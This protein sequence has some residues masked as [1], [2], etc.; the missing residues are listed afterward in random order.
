MFPCA[1]VLLSPA[2][3]LLSAGAIAAPI[4]DQGR[5]IFVNHA[6][7]GAN[8]GTSWADAFHHPRPALAT[9]AQGDEIWIARGSYVTSSTGDVGQSFRVERALRMFGG[10]VGNE[11]VR[12]QRN[13]YLHRT[14]LTGRL[15]GAHAQHVVVVGH[16]DPGMALLDGLEITGGAAPWRGG[17]IMIYNGGLLLKDCFLHDNSAGFHRNG[18]GDGGAISAH[19]E[20]VRL[21]VERCVFEGNSAEDGGG[22]VMIRKGVAEFTDCVFRRNLTSQAGGGFG[23]ALASS[24]GELRVIRGS[25]EGNRG[26]ALTSQYNSSIVV[27]G[28]TFRGNLG[29]AL[30]VRSGTFRAC[31]FLDNP[32]G[33]AI[34]LRGGD[35]VFTDCHFEG[36]GSDTLVGA[37]YMADS[38]F[39]EGGGLDVDRCVFI[40]NRSTR[41]GAISFGGWR[42]T[43]TN[44]LFVANKS[45]IGSALYVDVPASNDSLVMNCT[46][47]D[48]VASSGAAAVASISRGD[49]PTRFLNCI[50]WGNR[51]TAGAMS[52]WE[53]LDR[54]AR[55]AFCAIQ[56]HSSRNGFGHTGADPMFRNPA[57]GD[58]HLQ[59]ASPLV[60][61]GYPFSGRVIPA[62]HNLDF[63]RELRLQGAVVD[64][65][66]DEV[67]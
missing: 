35:Y 39:H 60:D 24:E 2:F 4:A 59:A 33:A 28:T 8:N 16:Q 25:F 54:Y 17:G 53:Q 49:N 9:A 36:N 66:A 41:G 29:L 38:V 61:A 52:E 40:G 51:T 30:S 13:P 42:L 63:D 21:Q 67:W 12:T 22:A 15:P 44:S 27:T 65:G 34:L 20:W 10:F 46:F 7:T 31:R 11:T 14:I 48:N 43:L 62:R 50:F 56:N 32:A 5:V 47:V 45:V 6:A 23:G 18:N 37:I 3:T 1:L 58:Y 19:D 55:A 64:I 26:T 57:A